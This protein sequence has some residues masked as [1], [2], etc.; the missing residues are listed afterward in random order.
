MTSAEAAMEAAPDPAEVLHRVWGYAAFR[1]PQEDVIRQVIGGGD[2]IVLMP[3]GGG[4]SLCYQVPALCRSG[5]AVVISPLI[6]LMQDQVRA[7]ELL[8]VRAAALNSALSL[9]EAHEVEKKMRRGALDLVY[10]APE[11]LATEA[12]LTHLDHCKIALFAIDEAH[13]VSQWGHDFRPEYRQLGILAQRYRGVPRMALTATADGPTRDDIA[14]QLNLT[15]AT[16]FVTGFDRPN[17]RYRIGLKNNGRKQLLDFLRTE[18][19]GAAGIVYCGT[20]ASVEDTAQWLAREGLNAVPYHA[21]LPAEVRED[22]LHR[23]LT[24]DGVIVVATIAFGMGIDKP[25]VRFVAHLDLPKS[26]EAYYQ[27]TGRA[28]RDGQAS[29]AWMVFGLQ[30]VVRQLQW[31][32]RSAAGDGQKRIERRKLEQLLGLCETTRCRRQVLLEALGE[33][34]AEPC[35]NCDTCLEPV[36]GFDGTVPAQKVLSCVYRTGQSFGA[37]HIVDVLMG[38]A[39]D[40]AKRF[41]H[42]TIKTFGAGTEMDQ[43]GW[44]SVIR[45]LVAMGLLNAEP[46]HGGLRLG[47]DV[48]DVLRGERTLTLRRD[49]TAHR[50]RGGAGKVTAKAALEN[51]ADE[52]LFQALRA[53]RKEEATE[54][55][56]PPYV[57]LHDAT[58]I[59]V[60]LRRPMSTTALADIPGVGKSKLERYGAALLARVAAG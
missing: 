20:R 56:V 14:A 11:R 54:Q 55:G 41:G 43:T 25:D 60:A 53:W 42:D 31:I 26:V 39:T 51:P 18:H 47:E 59:E 45:Q 50:K 36:E 19:P 21:G 46:E 16:R 48:R 5:V 15:D 10:V 4:K 3:T 32:D 2:A 13:C 28:G 37:A 57:I 33:T 40:K 12:F 1:G 17:I 8:G 27:E 23:F 22:T 29:D 24:E 30:D 38:K 34:L 6:A 7:L 9:A 52:A 58:L 35:G 44:R 49:P